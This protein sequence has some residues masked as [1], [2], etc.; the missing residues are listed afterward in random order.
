MYYFIKEFADKETGE[1]V[2]FLEYLEAEELAKIVEG[3][4]IHKNYEREI[5]EVNYQIDFLKNPQQKNIP[6]NL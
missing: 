3:L 6:S 1:N 2:C 4:E 5:D